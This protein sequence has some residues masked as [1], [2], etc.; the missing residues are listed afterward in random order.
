MKV[1][2]ILFIILFWLVS[3]TWGIIMTTI[4]AVANGLI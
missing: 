2:K 4:G 3:C 1:K